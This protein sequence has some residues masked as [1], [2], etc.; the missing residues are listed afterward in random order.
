MKDLDGNFI[1]ITDEPNANIIVWGQSGQG[2]TYFG[3]RRIEAAVASGK[4]VL[5]LDYSGSY[6]RQELS[7]KEFSVSEPIRYYDLEKQILS[8]GYCS[9]NK[10]KF[11]ADVADSLMV[12]LKVSSY[13]QKKWLRKMVERYMDN[14]ERFVMPNFFIAAGNMYYEMLAEGATKDDLDNIQRLLSRLSPYERLTN[15]A[16]K[17]NT[18][19]ESK[20]GEVAILQLSSLS[21]L[22]RKFVTSMIL[23]L[24][25][26]DV[27]LEPQ[28]R[29]CD[30]LL[31]DEFQFL[32]W[33]EDN[34]LSNI[35]R[36]GRKFGLSTM[37]CTQYISSFSKDVLEALMQAGHIFVFKPSPTDIKFSATIIDDA[38][39]Q[40]WMKLFES[41]SIGQA[42]L[43]GSFCINENTEFINQ[44]II[45]KI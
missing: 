18:T 19:R 39:R 8:W 29:H 43:K 5:V 15:F 36:E 33:T 34:S 11:C 2:K 44:P 26:K 25:W 41:L 10:E 38:N 9:Q 14:E 27:Y 31:L 24:I 35:L 4:R 23:E 13:I 40:V 1:Q 12:V 32:E 30:M 37:L 42:V 22:E 16:I 7:K 21:L 3:C 17:Q 45:V 28:N 6:T 20:P